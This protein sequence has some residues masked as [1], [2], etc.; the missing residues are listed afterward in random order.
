MAGIVTL[1]QD[2]KVFC[3]FSSEKKSLPY[4]GPLSPNPLFAKHRYCIHL[5]RLREP[6]MGL[7]PLSIAAGSGRLA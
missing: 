5:P 4:L 3:F 2:I 1:A 7:N 6:R